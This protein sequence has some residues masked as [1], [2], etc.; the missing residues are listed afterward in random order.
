MKSHES[1]ELLR[2]CEAVQVPSGSRI[3]LPRGTRVV[4]T[5]SLGDTWTVTTDYGHMVRISGKD[6]DALGL[7]P[8]EST[9]DAAAVTS[10]ED[11]EKLV[12]E[13]LKTCFDPEIPVNIVDL[14]LVYECRVTALPSGGH[15]VEVKMTLTAPGCGMG[16]VIAADAET[17]IA[18]LPTVEQASVEV[19]FDPPWNPSLMSEAARLEL[20]MM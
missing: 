14:G 13:R 6:A 17:K 1:V 10:T 5:Q 15:R 3:V 19:V 8:A 18:A 4:V 9:P 7:E 2:D 11:L 20:G 12:W 16:G